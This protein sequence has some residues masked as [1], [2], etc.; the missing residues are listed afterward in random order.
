[1]Y[2][3]TY[4][5]QTYKHVWNAL[6]LWNGESIMT[7]KSWFQCILHIN[8]MYIYTHHSKVKWGWQTHSKV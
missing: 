7:L 2:T 3:H 1:M 8:C 4:F 6:K 5:T